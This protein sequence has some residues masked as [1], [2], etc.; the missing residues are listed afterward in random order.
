MKLLN[1]KKQLS[2]FSAIMILIIAVFIVGITIGGCSE[3]P[4]QQTKES[5]KPEY[6]A[7]VP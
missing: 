2:S 4:E 1:H 7:N 3:T 6:S 5:P